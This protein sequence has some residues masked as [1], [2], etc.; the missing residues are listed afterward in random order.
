M[1]GGML[2]GVVIP[3]VVGLGLGAMIPALVRPWSPCPPRTSAFTAS[4]CA[5]LFAAM[6]GHFD[7]AITIVT[8]CIMSF[9]LLVSSTID[10][11]THRLPR[12]I[13]YA[14]VALGAP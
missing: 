7:D 9:G 3:G 2:V 8:Y 4:T 13:S 6:A 11:G 12:E 1:N 10:I 14:T 5:V